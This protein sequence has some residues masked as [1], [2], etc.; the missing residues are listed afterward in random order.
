MAV[1]LGDLENIVLSALQQPGI[2][3]GVAT[4]PIWGGV[5]NPNLSQG[6]VD[7]FINEGY[8]RVC[9]A[10]WPL[11]LTT[12]TFALTTTAGIASYAIPPAGN[13]MMMA[14]RV[15]DVVYLP[16]GATSAIRFE[17]GESLLSWEAF[18]RLT[19]QGY[20]RANSSGLYP[21][22]AAIG[23][24]RRTLEIY[25]NPL[26][27]GDTITI[28]YPAVPTPGT[29]QVPTLVAQSDTILL[30]DE[31]SDAIGHW[32]CYRLNWKNNATNDMKL[33]RALYKEELLELQETYRVTSM[34]DVQQFTDQP[35]FP[36]FGGVP[37]GY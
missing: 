28:T 9:T 23:P 22:C 3:F 21:R 13:P 11:R 10:L 12:A 27:N 1:A 31:A 35:T 5:T 32:A 4:Y 17:P 25:P 19:G 20:L 37:G 18:M 16:L 24:S 8:R 30:P 29:T 33:N 36:V 14:G 15:F 2:N 26:E 34:G 6:E 7:Y